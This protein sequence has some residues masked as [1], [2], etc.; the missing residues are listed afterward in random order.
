MNITEMVLRFVAGGSLVL[1][2][3]LFARAK[4]PLLAGLVLLFP[5]VTLV[6][7]FFAGRAVGPNELRKIS[8]FSMAGLCATLAFLG[9]FY[10][11]VGKI[12]L[13]PCLLLATAAWCAAA[14]VVAIIARTFA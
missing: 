14:G 5:M 2:A 7:L 13:V 8:L 3:S 6:G 1:A 11:L 4:N 10:A 9:A 12:A